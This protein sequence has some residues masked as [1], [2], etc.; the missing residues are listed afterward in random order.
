MAF[1]IKDSPDFKERGAG[2]RAIADAHLKASEKFGVADKDSTGFKAP[3]VPRGR[4]YGLY[5]KQI[6][7]KPAYTGVEKR[8]FPPL[9][10]IAGL[11]DAR[12]II[13]V[14]GIIGIVSLGAALFFLITERHHGAEPTANLQPAQGSQGDSF[15]QRQL[16]RK[17][18]GSGPEKEPVQGNAAVKQETASP[19]KHDVKPETP[20]LP[21]KTVS[22]P[23]HGKRVK[24]G[25]H[26]IAASARGYGAQRNIPAVEPN[27]GKAASTPLETGTGQLHVHTYPWA[28]M[29]IDDIFQ[30]TTPTPNPILLAAG[31]HSLV[32]KRDGYKP[33]SSTVHIDNGDITRVRIQ[34]EK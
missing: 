5:P 13:S 8:K 11:K 22:P 27:A 2:N 16:S 1:S 28:N 4:I 17:P 6:E 20:A 31:E 33:D 3:N 26:N 12:R 24:P 25:L 21:I 30:G 18:A 29:Y 9:G 19:D 23:A 10:I 15:K 14:A 7:P 34:L 32:L